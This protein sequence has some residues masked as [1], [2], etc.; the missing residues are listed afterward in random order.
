ML[1]G[2][3]GNSSAVGWSDW[4]TTIIDS[5]NFINQYEFNMKFQD[6]YGILWI[7]THIQYTH[8]VFKETL[9]KNPAFFQILYFNN[10]SYLQCKD[11]DGY[12]FKK[13]FQ[14]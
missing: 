10:Q 13:N 9:D 2:G 6:V 7:A 1:D 14:N 5:E 11:K 3:L 12:I 8:R 4:C